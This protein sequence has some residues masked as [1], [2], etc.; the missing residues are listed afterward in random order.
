M[1]NGGQFC[2]NLQ[3]TTR[4]HIFTKVSSISTFET[5]QLLRNDIGLC[6]FCEESVRTP[7]ANGCLAVLH[8]SNGMSSAFCKFIYEE[9]HPSKVSMGGRNDP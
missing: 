6:Y 5:S 8:S 1:G 9:T 7:H 4:N 3:V 2:R